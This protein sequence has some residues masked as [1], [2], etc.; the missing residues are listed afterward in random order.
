[1][2]TLELI[3]AD[4]LAARKARDTV[5]ATVLTTLIAEVCRDTKEPTEKRSCQGCN[6][7]HQE[8]E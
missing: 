7:V 8:F 4:A 2:T 3:K 1:M 6:Q 5:K